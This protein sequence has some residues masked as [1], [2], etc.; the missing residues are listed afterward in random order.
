MQDSGCYLIGDACLPDTLVDRAFGIILLRL[1][2]L[3]RERAPEWA[4]AFIP[5]G[6]G[7]TLLRPA[8]SST[9]HSSSRSPPAAFRPRA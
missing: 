4:L 8:I 1:R 9:D 3:F 2:L 5:T 7:G 6:W